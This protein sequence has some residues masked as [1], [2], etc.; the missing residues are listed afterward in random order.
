MEKMVD[1]P[2]TESVPQPLADFLDNDPRFKELLQDAS[3][4]SLKSDTSDYVGR[5]GYSWNEKG[6]IVDK[7]GHDVSPNQLVGPAQIEGVTDA[8]KRE[9]SDKYQK[10][11]SEYEG[12]EKVRVYES[13]SSDPAYAD[14]E[15]QITRFTNQKN[16]SS[17]GSVDSL[18]DK[19]RLRD[20]EGEL[21][22]T[23]HWGKFVS[24]Y[25]EKASAYASKNEYIA[26]AIAEEEKRKQYWENL[27]K[28]KQAEKDKA[29]IEEIR[30]SLNGEP[31]HENE[32]PIKGTTQENQSGSEP[33][34]REFWD[35]KFIMKDEEEVYK[36]PW[37]DDPE[38]RSLQEN[39]KAETQQRITA[40]TG[41]HENFGDHYGSVANAVRNKQ[42]KEFVT[43][44]PEKAKAY[45]EHYK[46]IRDIL[47]P[48]APTKPEAVAENPVTTEASLEAPVI[49][50]TV[51][52]EK[53]KKV[54]ESLSKEDVVSKYL[55]YQ[56][57]DVSADEK[58]AMLE[59]TLNPDKSGLKYAES[60]QEIL[61]NNPKERVEGVASHMV[62]EAKDILK[63]LGVPGS[64]YLGSKTWAMWDIGKQYHYFTHPDEADKKY[65]IADPFKSP[66]KI[67][68]IIDRHVGWEAYHTKDKKFA[69]RFRKNPAY[70]KLQELLSKAPKS[71]NGDLSS[72]DLAELG[73]VIRK[74]TI[75]S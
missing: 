5:Q 62:T 46:E 65:S 18:G 51:E 20:R 36:N 25:P 21:V 34:T 55:S 3:K 53:P 10:D 22:S 23:A 57:T 54:E 67:K 70:N 14:A 8:A 56:D 49:E 24:E 71:N 35:K 41:T 45:Q 58:K 32:V 64:T 39:I 15:R 63:K 48:P 19:R 50:K 42:W 29:R 26:K 40:D 43:K 2:K 47:N 52:V 60:L 37:D 31:A 6:G 69:E 44:Y 72:K 9:F 16:D 73:S 66:E 12:R 17:F 27:E 11:F 38:L 74:I 30:R 1:I 75:E 28:S 33:T 4:D 59:Y 7:E 13:P 68:E 61:V